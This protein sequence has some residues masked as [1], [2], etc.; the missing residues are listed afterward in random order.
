[1]EIKQNL[2]IRAD[3]SRKIGTGHVM[4]CLALAQAWLQ[5]GEQVTLLMGTAAPKLKA[6]LKAEGIQVAHLSVSPGSGEDAEQTIAQAKALGATWLV[7]DGYH[8]GADY[9]R[10]IKEAGLRLL[11]IDDYGHAAHYWADLVLNQNVYAHEG[12]Y[13]KRESYTQLLLG[14]QYTL[15]RKEFWP[16]Q[17]WQRQIPTVARKV[18]V[19]LGGADPDNVTLKVIQALQQVKVEGLEAV[20]VVGGSNPHYEQLQAAVHDSG[21]AITLKY[22]V[23]NMPEL[24]AWA[25][26]AIAAGGSTCW[27]L[28]FMGNP[29]LVVILA[30][31][32]RQV[33]E[34][35]D[36]CG[37][38]I[39]LGWHTEVLCEPLAAKIHGLL[40]A[41]ELRQE[42]IEDA[43]RLVD[44][45][46]SARVLIH[47]QDQKLRLRAVGKDD[48]E[49]L[50][51]WANDPEVRASAFSSTSIPWQEHVQWFTRKLQDSNCHILIALNRQD[52]PIG[53]IRF[54]IQDSQ[55]AE[56]DI[57]L[58]KSKRG[59]GFGSEMIKLAVNQ[60]FSCTS[61]QAVHAF[62]KPNN[63]PSIKAFEKAQFR[64][65]EEK[66][67]Q[68]NPSIHYV[69]IRAVHECA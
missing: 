16:W 32:Q 1:M 59:L 23:T 46:G 3:A 68:E 8:F 35:L 44:G 12:L 33:A 28:A 29:S 36:A 24:M 30:E 62:I 54:D 25:D 45:E 58:D 67:V 10:V 56:I 5:Q 31:N 43:Q 2:L 13:P 18:L 21:A 26:I 49:L 19:T 65:A 50:W 64:K 41:S 20:V 51:R 11:F 39:N 66:I 14:T 69:L 4:R 57:S 22:N 47:L 7:V 42:M 27:E 37:S 52:N 34:K 48:C 40:N 60:I 55:Q 17:G 9:Q 61:V 6:R 15:L 38:A 63:Y 53:Q